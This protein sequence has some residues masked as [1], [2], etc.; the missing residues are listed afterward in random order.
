MGDSHGLGPYPSGSAS[1]VGWGLVGQGVTDL[2]GTR[3][4]KTD[5]SYDNA[6]SVNIDK[7][8]GKC[9][10]LHHYC[11]MEVEIV[12][13]LQAATLKTHHQQSNTTKFL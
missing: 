1:T 9:K 13:N 12:L 4:L 11:S 3:F 7:C 8:L 10:K 5:C 2:R 6:Q